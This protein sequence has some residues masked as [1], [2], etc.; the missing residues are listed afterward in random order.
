VLKFKRKFRRLKVN[1]LSTATLCYKTLHQLDIRDSC[2]AQEHEI[3]NVLYILPAGLQQKKRTDDVALACSVNAAMSVRVVTLGAWPADWASHADSSTTSIFMVLSAAVGAADILPACLPVAVA[4]ATDSLPITVLQCRLLQV[5]TDD[6][7]LYIALF[8][9]AT[10][11]CL[12]TTVR[13]TT[14]LDPCRNP[15]IHQLQF[16]M[17]VRWSVTR[18]WSPSRGYMQ[19]L[20]KQK[21]DTRVPVICTLTKPSNCIKYIMATL[22]KAFFSDKLFSLFTCTYLRYIHT[23]IHTHTHTHVSSEEFIDRTAFLRPT[24]LYHWKSKIADRTCFYLVR[25]SSELR[26][27]NDTE[28]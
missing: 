2:Y 10:T 27:W 23:Y 12:M 28:N 11:T 26:T 7:S 18:V 21:D 19:M 25:H 15:L 9:H 5:S 24:Y 1:C 17:A 13:R 4:V 14:N 22:F 16:V 3:R 6:T 20:Q 8:I